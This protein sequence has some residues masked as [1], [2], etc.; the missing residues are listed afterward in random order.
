MLLVTSSARSRVS[1][2]IFRGESFFP[3]I[4]AGHSAVHLPHSVQEKAFNKLTQLRSFTSLAPNLATSAGVSEA[5]SVV[6]PIIRLTSLVTSGIFRISPFGFR[7]VYQ[8]LGKAR[9]I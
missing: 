9:K 1:I 4:L 2:I 6:T 7:L 3:V 5:F 8:V